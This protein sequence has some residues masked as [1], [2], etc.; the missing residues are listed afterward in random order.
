[1]TQIIY[2]MKEVVSDT[3]S[4]IQNK[5]QIACINRVYILELCEP[6]SRADSSLNFHTKGND[7]DSNNG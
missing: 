6:A 7:A 1:M 3:I 2:I 4:L 5:R